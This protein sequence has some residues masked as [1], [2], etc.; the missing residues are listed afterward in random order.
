MIKY[1]FLQAGFTFI[2]FMFWLGTT[3]LPGGEVGMAPFLLGI[4][5]LIHLTIGILISLVFRKHLITRNNL[6]IGM[7]VY[8]GI[9][10]LGP[11]LVGGKP[12]ILAIFEEDTNGETNRAFALIPLLAGLIT[13]MVIGIRER[14][15]AA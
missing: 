7:L 11:L 4:F 1:L 9:Y 12:M 6:L 15:R 5:L 8:L 13:L 10:E 3:S 2:F 14:K